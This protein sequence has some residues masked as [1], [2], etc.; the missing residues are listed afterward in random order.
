MK[1]PK[2]A[3]LVITLLAAWGG[4]AP[5][6]PIDYALTIPLVDIDST[7]MTATSSL[8]GILS[9][10]AD[11]MS[12]KGTFTYADA[13]G[14]FTDSYAGFAFL[15][16]LVDST[17]GVLF[18]GFTLAGAE[19]YFNIIADTKANTIVSNPV[20][21]CAVGCAMFNSIGATILSGGILP[22]TPPGGS[23][24]PG[25]IGGSS[26]IGTPGGVSPVPLPPAVSLFSGALLGL[27]ALGM[28]RRLALRPQVATR[29]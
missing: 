18:D 8:S 19:L 10:D 5:A 11:A 7:S 2:L 13:S 28:G 1:T 16:P 21:I 20:N 24:S 22:A 12:G 29:R 27:A 9:Y 17:M 26:G 4:P 3:A 23:A 6:A 25:G 15:L 14:S